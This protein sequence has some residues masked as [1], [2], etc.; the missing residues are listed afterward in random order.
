MNVAK[1]TAAEVLEMIEL[2]SSNNKNNTV[3]KKSS[4]KTVGSRKYRRIKIRK[5]NH[6]VIDKDEG[7]INNLSSPQEEEPIVEN[8]IVPWLIDKEAT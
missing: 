7:D 8:I 2:L 3:P 4:N 6:R 5:R 1:R